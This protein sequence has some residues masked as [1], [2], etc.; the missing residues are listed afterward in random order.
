MARLIGRHLAD[1]VGQPVHID[2]KPGGAGNIASSYVARARPDG[3]TLY[4]ATD[5]ISINQTLFKERGYDALTSFAPIV[6]AIAAPQI[7]AVRPGV[8]ADN[9]R[10]FIEIAKQSPG[11]YALASPAIGTTGQ[12]GVLMLQNQAEIE[13]NPVVY[14]SAQPAL[15]D[16]LGNHADGIIVTLAPALPYIKENR[17][18]PIA[19]STKSRTAVLPECRLLSSKACRVSSSVPGRGSW[20]LR[21]RPMR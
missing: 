10:G 20:R 15:T 17:L 8:P 6:Q 19:V 1:K 4:V 12:L 3:Y 21:A 5:V 2:N 14:R 16:V 7:F 13:L 11:R 9:L 18:K